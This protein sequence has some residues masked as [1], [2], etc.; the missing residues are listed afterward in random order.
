MKNGGDEI[1]EPHKLHVRRNPIPFENA[2]LEDF[3][4]RNQRKNGKQE[5]G[6]GNK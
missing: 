4:E 3:K 2:E 6:G 1:P 5:D